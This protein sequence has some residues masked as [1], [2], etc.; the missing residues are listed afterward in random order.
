MTPTN[1]R[2]LRAQL[3]SVGHA[4]GHVDKV[5]VDVEDCTAATAGGGGDFFFFL[6]S[7]FCQLDPEFTRAGLQ[8]A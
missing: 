6:E 5:D 1:A 8:S 2:Y 7:G 3:I 4:L